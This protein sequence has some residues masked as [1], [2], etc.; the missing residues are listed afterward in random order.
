MDEAQ[1]D[2]MHDYMSDNYFDY[3]TYDDILDWLEGCS[4]DE[5]SKIIRIANI[6]RIKLEVI[7]NESN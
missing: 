2:A 5:L 3:I 4:I 6:L 7:K 1:L